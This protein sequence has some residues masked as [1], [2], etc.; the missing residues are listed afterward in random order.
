VPEIYQK[1]GAEMTKDMPA[2]D[3]HHHK[4]FCCPT[5]CVC[6]ICGVYLSDWAEGDS[7]VADL[8]ATAEGV[9]E[10]IERALRDSACAFDLLRRGK[11][12]DHIYHLLAENCH[13]ALSAL[14]APS[15]D[16]GWRPIGDVP[17]SHNWR[18]YGLWV[19]QTG[20]FPT[21]KQKRF[22]AYQLYIDDNGDLI[23][24]HGD[25]FTAWS[26][27][28]FEFVQEIVPPPSKPETGE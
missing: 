21:V 22:E 18:L 17:A 26:L 13:R 6:E 23:D 9:D 10:V 19:L 27:S 12:E 11:P 15:R 5:H 1:E 16:D 8:R 14:R 25:I 4:W 24:N 3:Q 20:P 28:D 2:A 7:F